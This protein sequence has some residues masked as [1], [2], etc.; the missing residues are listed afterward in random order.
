MRPCLITSFEPFTTRKGLVLTHNPTQ[1][2]TTWID[3]N[4]SNIAT[5]VLPVAFAATKT[6]LT[7]L[8]DEIAPEIW[9]GLGY[10]PHREHIDVET[11]ALN[12]EH[13]VRPD[14]A[15]DKAQL[16]PIIDG[17]PL[18]YNAPFNAAQLVSHLRNQGLDAQLSFHAGTFMCNQVLY[19]GSHQQAGG[20]SIQQAGFVH[21]PPGLSPAVLG[22]ALSSWVDTL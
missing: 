17:A 16:R 7:R 1:E 20:K 19:L 18:A 9:I 2:I 4:R 10:A 21:I 13:A 12:I 6:R 14:N 5:A 22:A 3:Q 15:G 11:I 8:F